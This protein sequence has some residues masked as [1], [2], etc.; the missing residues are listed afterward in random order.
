MCTCT[1]ITSSK[2][3]SNQLHSNDNQQLQTISTP[4]NANARRQRMSFAPHYSPLLSPKDIIA[5]QQQV[6]TSLIHAT[7]LVI[8]KLSTVYDDDDDTCVKAQSAVIMNATNKSSLCV[9][10][11]M[12]TSYVVIVDPAAAKINKTANGN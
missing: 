12:Q 8:Q 6:R 2:I 10:T 7:Q 1:R 4:T 11:S 5:L 9:D 3:Q